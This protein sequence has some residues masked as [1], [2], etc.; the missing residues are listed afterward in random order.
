MTSFQFAF[1]GLAIIALAAVMASH[2]GTLSGS[3]RVGLHLCCLAVALLYL[4]WA[5]LGGW[6]SGL[7]HAL[8]ISTLA[9][10]AILCTLS[11]LNWRRVGGLMVLLAPYAILLL[12]LARALGL[13]SESGAGMT[14]SPVPQSA[15][16]MVHIVV[17]VCAYAAILLAAIAGLSV[18]WVERSLKERVERGAVAAALPSVWDAE[19]AKNVFLVCGELVLGA[20][21]LSGM[22]LNSLNG[23]PFFVLDHKTLLM[24]GAF[25]VIGLLL[26]GQRLFSVRGR[27]AARVVLVAYL[28]L[29]LGYPGVKFVTEVLLP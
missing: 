5:L 21:L 2:L 18:F 20:G 8:R 15:W 19:R 29:T 24:L 4:G 11:V 14:Q 25:V 26:A 16:L 7:S 1:D 17:A 28:L 12:I 10:V 13:A 22:A 3:V 9:A 23:A 27:T 6:H